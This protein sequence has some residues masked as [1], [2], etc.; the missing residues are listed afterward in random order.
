MELIHVESGTGKKR[1]MDFVYSLYL[2]NVC[3]K[4]SLMTVLKNFLYGGDTFIRKSF[5]KPVAVIEDGRTLAQCIV[6][7]NSGLPMIQV[8]FFEAAP[9]QDA[10]VDLIIDE[11]YRCMNEIGVDRAVFGLNG[12]L[13]YGVGYLTGHFDQPAAFDSHYTL[14]YY[15]EYF[16]RR[17]FE[18]V[19]LKCYYMRSNNWRIDPLL[20]DKIRSKIQFR[21]MN[22]LKFKEEVLLFSR[23]CNETLNDTY[24]YYERAPEHLYELVNELRVFLKP[25]NL[26]F[27]MHEGREVGFIFWHPDYNQIIQSGRR[28]S[29]IRIGVDYFLHR[30]RINTVKLNVI[31][32][33]P[34]F[35]KMG[36]APGLIEE[37]AHY[38]KGRYEFCETNFVWDSNIE[39]RHMNEM[40]M[41][42]VAREYSVFL[43][44]RGE[45]K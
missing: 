15:P 43:A 3:Y 12:H 23:L 38:C 37:M 34:E 16:R 32:V 42:G 26:I 13:H 31:G 40:N 33:L 7:H 18:E 8:A 4:D 44:S 1:F 24:L 9:G 28:N 29:V 5:V 27:A 22:R 11:V 17:G 10:A 45:E 6:F 20:H 39:S 41:E 2:E 36:V 30:K 35:R 14:P 25:E 19:T 21:T